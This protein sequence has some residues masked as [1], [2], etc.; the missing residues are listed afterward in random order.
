MET[1]QEVLV[2]ELKDIYNAEK[3]LLQALPKMARKATSPALREALSSHLRET[4]NQVRRL[5]SIADSLGTTLD[6]KKCAAM[7]GLIA[8]G[9]AYIG[10]KGQGPVIDAALIGAAQ[11]VEH[12]EMAAYGNARALAEE[13]GEP[14]LAELLQETLDEERTADK[15]LTVISQS[16]VFPASRGSA[17]HDASR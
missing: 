13:L 15:T 3:Q 8:E 5:E 12:Y 14:E 4:E 6:G 10:M 9:D 16:E 17:P 1:L 7:Q 2:D 11:R